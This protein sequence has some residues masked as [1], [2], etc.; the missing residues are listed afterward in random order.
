[1]NRCGAHLVEVCVGSLEPTP[2]KAP[3]QTYKAPQS[4][5][6]PSRDSPGLPLKLHLLP[7]PHC[8][9]LSLTVANLPVPVRAMRCHSPLSFFMLF[10][11]PG[12]LFLLVCLATSNTPFKARLKATL[13][14]SPP[15]PHAE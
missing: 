11:L 8:P 2:L 5:D 9:P 3:L 6:G 1:M 7:S 12:M 13:S 14:G 4:T 10:F 15:L